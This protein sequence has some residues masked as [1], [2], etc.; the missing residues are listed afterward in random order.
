MNV[1]M[2][3]RKRRKIHTI[4]MT[5]NEGT[6]LFEAGCICEEWLSGIS[7]DIKDEEKSIKEIKTAFQGHIDSL[8]YCECVVPI[9]GSDDAMGTRIR[10]TICGKEPS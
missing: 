8:P 6:K 4:I 10:C 9:W 3:S 7:F 5:R 2:I 1:I